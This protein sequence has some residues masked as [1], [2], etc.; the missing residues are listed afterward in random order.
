MT[1]TEFNPVPGQVDR[2]EPGLRRVLAPNPSPMTYRGTNTYLL[3]AGEVAVIDP[4]PGLPAHLDAI[5]AALGP[6]ERIARIFVTHSH[7]DHSELAP[8]LA[9]ATGAP[10]LAFGDS[11]AGRSGAMVRLAAAGLLGGG[12]GA[13][14]AFAPDI[15]I[16]DGETVTGAGGALTAVWT[17][18]HFGNHLSFVWNGAVFTGDVAMGWASSLVSPP[19]GDMGAYMA[20]LERLAGLGARRLYPAHGAPIDAPAARLAELTAHRRGREAAIRAGLAAGPATAATLASRIYTD[21]PAALMPAAERNVLAHLLDLEERMLARAEPAPGPA[22]L[23]HAVEGA[24]A[25]A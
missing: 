8:A 14:A 2:L 11:L 21:T 5:L 4:G 1:Q 22:A 7:R 18:G 6:G 9:A 19:E 23:W 16:A 15:L 24:A 10:I 12:E 13:D 17:P 3:G 20:S 25:G